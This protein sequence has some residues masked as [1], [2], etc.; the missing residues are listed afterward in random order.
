MQT[1]LHHTVCIGRSS[2][3]KM[4]LC[5]RSNLM[6]QYSGSEESICLNGLIDLGFA[7]GVGHLA[8]N[9]WLKRVRERISILDQDVGSG[10]YEM[11]RLCSLPRSSDFVK[12]A[13][14]GEAVWVSGLL[15]LTDHGT[16]S[17]IMFV[18]SP[19]LTADFISIIIAN[20]KLFRQFSW[21]L[22]PQR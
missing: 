19:G 15:T 10:C 22:C 20:A 21:Q 13:K 1:H 5:L 9:M 11:G 2:K 17:S 6:Q 18:Q 14:E 12:A 16:V 3:R 4:W 7:N 8:K